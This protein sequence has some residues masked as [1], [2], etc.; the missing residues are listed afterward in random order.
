MQA[1]MI[2]IWV[3]TERNTNTEGQKGGEYFAVINRRNSRK[4]RNVIPDV[5][6]PFNDGTFA[7]KY[8]KASQSMGGIAVNIG[9]STDVSALEKNVK[10]IKEQG[11]RQIISSNDRVIVKYK[12]LTQTIKK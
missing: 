4:Y 7:D 9:S 11:E 12:N 6:N 10:A 3:M 5:I 1:V 8:Q 2:L